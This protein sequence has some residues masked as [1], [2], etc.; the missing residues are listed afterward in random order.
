MG[1]ARSTYCDKPAVSLDDTALVET[2]VTICESFEA[3]GSRRMQ[4]AL[5]HLGLI[6]N[7]K[8]IRRLM[9]EHS[10]QPRR[11]RRY[12]ATTDG[13]HELP[14][15]PNLARDMVPGG[16]NPLWVTD[17]TYVAITAG[18][19]Y[20]MLSNR[21]YRG[22]IVHKDVSHPGQ[23]DAIVDE[24]LFND[25]QQILATNR[26]DRERGV[27]ADEPSL[28]A[29]LLFDADGNR[30]T[31][32]HA[33]K[34]GV[35][36]RYY[37]SKTLITPRQISTRRHKDADFNGTAAPIAKDRNSLR[38]PAGDIE[39]LVLDRMVQLLAT[40]AEVLAISASDLDPNLHPDSNLDAV[41]QSALLE[42]AQRNASALVAADAVAQR[43][44]LLAALQRVDVHRD[45]VEIRIDR[46]GLLQ[47][48]RD[49]DQ[50]SRVGALDE[51]HPVRDD[52]VIGTSHPDE[53]A[54]APHSSERGARDIILLTVHVAFRRSGF[55]LR[56]VVPGKETGAR[57]DHSLVRLVARAHQM[58]DRLVADPDRTI[59]QLAEQERLTAS[60]LT[61][62]LRLAF[63]APDIVTAILDG[64]QPVE[65]TANKI[66]ADTRLSIDWSGQRQALGFE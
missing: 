19:V 21:L 13:D 23:H 51:D 57:P 47:R 39:R 48:V 54:L 45:R 43:G 17:I 9:R 30:M 33:S 31:P 65:L 49:D 35:R 28:L 26:V 41:G 34:K 64:R 63:V 22:E 59:T 10:L 5:R 40:P 14:I 20:V 3:Y 56:L 36:Y 55:E 44:F 24:A 38:L 66:M 29:G 18:F 6:V 46:T 61:R 11:R 7:H 42:A 52:G 62:L 27:N 12:I 4:A 2:M 50:P 37:V 32:T 16:P 8:K 15:F 25:V 1:I 58:R 60:Y 53:P